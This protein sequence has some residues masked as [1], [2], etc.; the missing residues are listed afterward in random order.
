MRAIGLKLT[1]L[2]ACLGLVLSLSPAAQ[3]QDTAD[4]ATTDTSSAADALP[5]LLDGDGRILIGGG[6]P[7]GVYFQLAG[8][9]CRALDSPDQA[10]CTIASLSDS[11]VA[12]DALKQGTVDFAIVQSDWLYHAVNGSSRFRQQ[13]PSENLVSVAA[14]HGEAYVIVTRDAAPALTLP[15][16]EGRRMQAGPEASYRGLLTVAALQSARLDID[17]LAK[18]GDASV[19]LALDE[20]CAN[21]TD[22]V[23]LMSAHPNAALSQA[24][25]ICPLDVMSFDDDT[26]ARL[27]QRLPG[28]AAMVLPAGTYPNQEAPVRTVGV[29]AVLATTRDADPAVVERIA[30]ALLANV[31]RIAAAH[32]ALTDLNRTTLRQAS[33]FAPLHSAATAV[34]QP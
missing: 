7:F 16:L 5:P 17:D 20:L 9:I 18:R 1:V 3:A 28:Y 32:P 13:G 26:V 15:E 25:S 8:A 33:A 21:G 12:L 11:A 34:F 24:Q 10:G 2:A 14:L 30:Q 6:L 4:D 29:R 23:A 19:P 31:K 22:A 27:L